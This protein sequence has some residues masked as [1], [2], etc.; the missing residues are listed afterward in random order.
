M[1]EAI[2]DAL[3]VPGARS[4]T[5]QAD[6]DHNRL[7]TTVLAVADAVRRSVA[8]RP[9]EAIEL[10]DM[11]QHTAGIR[12]WARSDV[13]PFMPVRDVTMQE[14]VALARAVGRGARRDARVPVYLYDRAALVARAREPR[15]R[16]QG[17]V[18]GSARGR[19]AGR[20]A[21][22]LR[23]ARDRT[24][25]RRGRRRAQA[26]RRVQRLLSGD[27][28]DA[29]KAIARSRPGILRGPPG[30]AGDRLRRAG[31]R[32]RRRCR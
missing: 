21:A 31:A 2:V 29:A 19:G 8:G 1:I 30:G 3:Q 25:R 28:E 18:R 15:R 20:A 26:A 7:D 12:G 9:R 23:P 11:E 27:D 6:P 22:R 24:R 13:I 32:V 4:C 14:C 10:I 5:R 16:A 17:R